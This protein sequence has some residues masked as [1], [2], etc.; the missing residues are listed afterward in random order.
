MWKY[1]PFLDFVEAVVDLSCV[2]EYIIINNDFF[3]TP[4]HDVLRHPKVKLKNSIKNIYVNPA[5]NLG[6]SLAQYEHL[7]ILNDDATLDLRAFFK[8]DKFLTKNSEKHNVGLV[9]ICPGWAGYGQPTI[10]DGTVSIVNEG[11]GMGWGTCFFLYK[12]NW[13][14]IPD[15]IKIFWGDV[16]VLYTQSITH[17]KTIWAIQNCFFH[18]PHNT[19]WKRNKTLEEIIEKDTENWKEIVYNQF[20][21]MRPYIHE[22]QFI[23]GY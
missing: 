9:G 22:I 6:V 16:W 11:I 20:E 3:N 7:C 13:I 5:W 10:T 23:R 18:T 1:P 12:K 8:T 19:T 4:K 14:P 21:S 15:N 17:N 2:G